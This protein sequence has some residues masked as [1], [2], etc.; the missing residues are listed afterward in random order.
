MPRGYTERD[1][2]GVS[3]RIYSKNGETREE[4]EH[5]ADLLASDD[6]SLWAYQADHAAKRISAEYHKAYYEANKDKIRGQQQ[7]YYKKLKG[8]KDELVRVCKE[9]AELAQ[10]VKS[11]EEQIK[12]LQEQLQGRENMIK[13]IMT[14]THAAP[15]GRATDVSQESGKG[16]VPVPERSRVT[17]SNSFDIESMLSSLGV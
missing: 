13:S 15:V 7:K 5:R 14:V 11:L 10:R 6:A 8:S 16:N 17:D 2:H 9:N 1:V 4:L 3:M 12:L